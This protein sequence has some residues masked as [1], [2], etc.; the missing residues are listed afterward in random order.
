MLQNQHL[1]HGVG[2][3]HLASLSQAR[4]AFSVVHL[5]RRE[6]T[7]GRRWA[8]KAIAVCNEFAMPMVLGQARVFFELSPSPG[9]EF[10]TRR[11]EA[12]CVTIGAEPDDPPPRGA[13]WTQAPDPHHAQCCSHRSW[14]TPAAHCGTA[15]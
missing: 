15:V 13:G 7:E 8:E 10:H 14:R 3:S 9:T 11:R 6:P 1:E 12:G 5:M 4:M 2:D